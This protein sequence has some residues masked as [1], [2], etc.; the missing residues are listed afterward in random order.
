M[1][2]LTKMLGI[3][4]FGDAIGDPITKRESGRKCRLHH[5]YHSETGASSGGH[6]EEIAFGTSR[7]M[8]LAAFVTAG[9][10]RDQSPEGGLVRDPTTF[11]IAESLV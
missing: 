7:S 5:V 8:M 4:F 11:A 2:E 9:R 3:I 6:L 1:V 10:D